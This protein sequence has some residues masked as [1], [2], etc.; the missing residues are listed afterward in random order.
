MDKAEFGVLGPV[1]ARYGEREIAVRGGKQRTVLAVL[2][3]NAGR[4]V[5][6]ERLIDAVWGE[7]PAPSA[8][9]A[10]RNYVMRLRRDLGPVKERIRTRPPGYLISVDPGEF[11]VSRFEALLESA[12][13]A[14]ESG[15]WDRAAERART[16]LELW[17]GEPLC[18]VESDSLVQ[19]EAPRLAELRLRAMETRIEADLRLG[20]P[21]EVVAELGYLIAAHPLRERLRAQL[22]LALY[23][24]GRQADAL[25][26]Y[27]NA[28]E[29]LVELLGVEPGEALRDL[30]QRI[31]SG[32]RTLAAP[33]PPGSPA[34]A[35][36]GPGPALDPRAVVPR[37]LPRAVGRF[38]GRD[39]ELAL[40]SGLLEGA[41]DQDPG[42]AV[43]SVIS[44]TA[45]VGKT[46]LAVLWAHKVSGRFPDGQLYVNLRGY[47]PDQPVAPGDAL[48]GFL[49]VLGL[50]AER[51]PAST[52]E[53]AAAF[54][55]MVAGRRV[56]VVLD[57]AREVEQIR[58]LLPGSSSCL[59]VVTSRD[60]MPGLV[61]RDGAVR[62]NLDL[63]PEE[64]SVRL[65][66]ELI[67]GRAADS[68]SLARL[69]ECCCRL[70]LALRVA[71]ELANA[72][73]GVPLAELAAELSDRQRRLDLLD[74]DGD[75]R[76]A[77]REVFSWSYRHL[78]ALAARVFRLAGLHPGPDFD[79]YAV[80][81]LADTG[82]AEA[83]RSLDRLARA[84]LIQSA[85]PGRYGLHDL[86]RDYARELAAGRD[87]EE[88]R[89]AALTRLLDHYL[90]TAGI[91]AETLSL[92]EPGRYRGIRRA[93]A[94][95]VP[96]VTDAADAMAWL[97]AERASLVAVAVHAA[98]NGWP[99]HAVTLSVVLSLYLDRVFRPADSRAIH[100]AAHR[101]AQA[102]ADRRGEISALNNL[103]GV[104]CRLGRF[105]AVDA[106]YQALASSREISDRD[107]EARTLGNLG[108]MSIH[109]GRFERA[110]EYL[111]QALAL[112]REAGDRQSEARVRSDLS[113][114]LGRWGHHREAIDHARKSLALGRE[115][116]NP[117]C[118]ATALARL[119]DAYLGAGRYPE[120]ANGFQ[121]A[122][123]LFREVGGRHGEAEVLV[124]LAVTDAKIGR[125]E[126]AVTNVRRGL[127][128]CR[129]V[130]EWLY[131]TWALTCAGD[132]LLSAGRPAEARDLFADGLELS[133]RIVLPY[134]QAR[135]HYG[136]G[137]VHL[138]FG[139][140]T[141]SRFH[142]ERA[143]ALFRTMGAPEA[144]HV[145]ACLSDRTES[146]VG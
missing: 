130:G 7:N 26:A 132:V 113:R 83:R 88:D 47:D 27:Q 141:R 125:L 23:Q 135:A 66:R 102:S 121:R 79:A 37:Q 84:N 75:V 13:A 145:R 146:W 56:L 131:T 57:N 95:P 138:E 48:A 87:G 72:R 15:S 10:V 32:D 142:L 70:P 49:R 30:H 17:R 50:P 99:G 115:L 20:R 58:P 43:I 1:L 114:A 82:L 90:H 11:D 53:R 103:A 108:V 39:R 4:V 129:E 117:D 24:S 33:V 73:V 116:G 69:A 136:L 97:E 81:A 124:C 143:L 28:R 120:A 22:M 86:L 128:L 38:V 8:D 134:E 96:A 52:D 118:E 41:D 112:C 12:R 94:A 16:A 93:A 107:G 29:E 74:T 14:G 25:A 21:A 46:A 36:A 85:G 80:A 65:L 91:A 40:L 54:R 42:S 68:D 9:V 19:R 67:G 133:G 137:R 6:T 101:A 126:Q 59:V 110:A 139:Q 76:S 71:A 111:S 92:R 63:L 61:A 51:I 122:L 64:E 100:D 123:G 62:V 2:L 31:L 109:L 105:Q 34:E 5:S 3:L 127:A 55:S 89:Q 119:G 45:G 104:D 35:S 140:P 18:D 60:G 78:D 44:G 144:D 106:L 98:D 77:V